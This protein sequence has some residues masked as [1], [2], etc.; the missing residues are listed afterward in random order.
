MRHFSLVR[1]AAVAAAGII[2]VGMATSAL[3]QFTITP[4]GANA[5]NGVFS[6]GAPATTGTG[7]GNATANFRPGNSTSPD[8]MFQ[9]QWWFRGPGDTR[10]FAF[11][12]QPA[13]APAQTMVTVGDNTGNLP[14][15]GFDSTVT[16]TA[17]TVAAQF[18]WTIVAGPSGPTVNYTA[19]FTNTGAA[20]I[21]LT[22]F[23]YKDFDVNASAGT[24]T[25]TNSGGN[26]YTITDGPSTVVW[27]SNNPPSAFQTTAFATLRTA[28]SDTAV[29][30]LTNTDAGS[31]GDFT[32]A[33]QYNLALAPNQPQTIAGS[34]SMSVPE[35]AS[36]G[37]L[38]VAALGLARRRRS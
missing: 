24:D 34:F 29:T 31:P 32:G 3:A 23:S 14:T 2:S 37:L 28:L 25:W 36:L 7:A 12:N 33:F 26:T 13:G 19:M 22:V 1:A 27:R 5:G 8:Q 30:N 18:R 35:P 20:P 11:A 10:E 38:G 16:S 9:D 4:G 21:D 17:Y 6:Q 15:G